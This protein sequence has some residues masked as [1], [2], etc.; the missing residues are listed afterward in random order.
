MV[1]NSI[2]VAV[3]SMFLFVNAD[4]DADNSPS[5][6]PTNQSLKKMIQVAPPLSLPKPSPT[7]LPRPTVIGFKSPTLQR[8]LRALY[9]DDDASKWWH[10]YTEFTIFVKSVTIFVKSVTIFTMSASL[11]LFWGCFG[12]WQFF[13]FSKRSLIFIDGGY[14]RGA[15]LSLPM[16]RKSC[17]SH[18][19]LPVPSLKLA[20]PHQI[21][22]KLRF[23]QIS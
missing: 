23:P 10:V 3:L 11:R 5:L 18:L 14:F 13:V 12:I 2:F 6:S 4:D 17:R 9:D 21:A 22:R 8:W 20:P 1:A 7:Q 15:V 16:E 19:S